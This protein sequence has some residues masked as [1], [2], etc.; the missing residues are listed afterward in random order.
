[1]ILLPLAYAAPT[2]YYHYLIRYDIT[3]DINSF[4]CKQTYA[5]RCYIATSNGVEALTI[6]VIKEEC[7]TA[8]KDIRISNHTPWQTLHYRAIE[9][10]YRSSPFFEYLYS[11]IADLY[12]RRYDFLVD[13]NI[14]LQ[15]K[16]L[17]LLG[18]KNLDILLSTEYI[19]ANDD[20]YTDLR[21]QFDAKRQSDSIPDMQERKYHQ[22][23]EHKYGFKPNLSIL[24]MLFNTALESRL[25]L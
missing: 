10:A 16:I 8:T 6:P 7:K 21:E 1:M 17:D 22:V 14:D 2:A 18:Y 25:L 19:A 9:S 12:N 24:D 23:F 3:I 11:D 15:Q 13:F 5:N 20:K 4:Y